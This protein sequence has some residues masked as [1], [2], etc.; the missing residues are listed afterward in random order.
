MEKLIDDALFDCNFII[1]ILMCFAVSCLCP[2]MGY[3]LW[4]LM[5]YEAAGMHTAMTLSGC[6]SMEDGKKEVEEEESSSLCLHLG[7]Q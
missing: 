7:M 5:Q 4:L 3:G 2:G 1:G 6:F